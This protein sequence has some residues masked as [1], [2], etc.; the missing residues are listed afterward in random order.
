[1]T[2]PNFSPGMTVDDFVAAVDYN[3]RTMVQWRYGQ[4]LFNTLMIHRPDLGEALR[5]KYGDPFYAEES[6]DMRVIVAW[7]YITKNW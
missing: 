3:V 4:A 5:G 2:L 7:A 6:T 1:M